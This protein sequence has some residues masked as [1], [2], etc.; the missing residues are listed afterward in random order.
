MMGQEDENLA[1]KEKLNTGSIGGVGRPKSSSTVPPI[2]LETTSAP[3]QP[4]GKS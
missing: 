4:F 1:T 3:G 2:L